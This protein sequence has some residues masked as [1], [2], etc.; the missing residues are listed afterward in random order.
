MFQGIGVALLTMFDS[1][2]AID[3]GATAAHAE[4]LIGLGVSAVIVAGT[5]GEPMSLTPQERVALLEAVKEVA[6]G[7]PVIA[8][9]GAPS[10]RE[11]VKLTK[12]A[13]DAGADAV[14]ALCPPG[15]VDPKAFYHA[16]A[17]AASDRPT[18]A[19]HFPA[20]SAP[21]FEP[22]ALRDF[23]VAGV[24]DSSGDARRLLSLLDLFDG[25]V[26]PGSPFLVSLAGSQ[27]AAGA[28]LAVANVAP[29]LAIAAFGGDAAAQASLAKIQLSQAGNRWTALK[30]VTAERFGTPRFA[31]ME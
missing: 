25:S 17:A 14:L 15:P 18:L 7:R 10:A 21:G 20:I 9:T 29:E 8:G 5:T 30:Q 28:I 13:V 24:K 6:A 4:R 22:A 23:G 2:G 16:V 3:T 1:S 11:S 27:G 31:R 19:Y 12:D 26:Y